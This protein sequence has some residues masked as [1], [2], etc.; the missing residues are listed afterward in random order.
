MSLANLRP[1]ELVAK[2]QRLQALCARAADALE[3]YCWDESG[4]NHDPDGAEL[5]AQLRKATE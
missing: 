4:L 3:A 5:V 2:I 1:F